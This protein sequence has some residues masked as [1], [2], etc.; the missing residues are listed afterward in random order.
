[1]WGKQ[2]CF[3][4]VYS[5]SFKKQVYSSK[6]PSTYTFAMLNQMSTVVV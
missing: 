4:N 5:K 2:Q 3:L 1:M 6:N